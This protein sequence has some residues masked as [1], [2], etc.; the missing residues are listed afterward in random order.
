MAIIRCRDHLGNGYESKI[1]MCKAWNISYAA[2]MSRI[3]SGLFLAE[4]LTWRPASKNSSMPKG[5]KRQRLEM[6]GLSHKDIDEVIDLLELPTKHIAKNSG[7]VWAKFEPA[8]ICP[9]TDENSAE[10][11]WYFGF[12]LKECALSPKA[13]KKLLLERFHV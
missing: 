9:R 6:W 11:R 12:T 1:A 4:A 8:H 10:A 5:R 7:R 13:F 3:K 2:F